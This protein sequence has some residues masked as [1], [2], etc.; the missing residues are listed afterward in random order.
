LN[1]RLGQLQDKVGSKT[2]QIQKLQKELDDALNQVDVAESRAMEA[3]RKEES[4]KKEAAEAKQSNDQDETSMRVENE[5][6]SLRERL[7]A[8]EAKVRQAQSDAKQKVDEVKSLEEFNAELQATAQ[9][10]ERKVAVL[11]ARLSTTQE[12]YK[13]EASKA[14]KGTEREMELARDRAG[15]VSMN[16]SLQE[17]LDRITELYEAAVS[18]SA[19]MEC[20]SE[21]QMATSVDFGDSLFGELQDISP[22]MP[23]PSATDAVRTAVTEAATT[24]ATAAPAQAPVLLSSSDAVVSAVAEVVETAA[25]P[26]ATTPIPAKEESAPPSVAGN[27][28]S[29]EIA[30][31]LRAATMSPQLNMSRLQEGKSDIRAHNHS[32]IDAAREFFYMTVQTIIIARTQPSKRAIE[33]A[34]GQKLAQLEESFKTA[35]ALA[36]A[37]G[38]YGDPHLYGLF[39]QATDGP[40]NTDKPSKWRWSACRKW[41]A[42]DALGEMSQLEAMRKYV[43]LVAQLSPSWGKDPFE[44]AGRLNAAGDDIDDDQSSYYYLS[45]EAIDALY[46]TANGRIPMQDWHTW[47][48][49]QLDSAVAKYK[50]LN[51]DEKERCKAKVAE[52]DPTSVQVDGPSLGPSSPEEDKAKAAEIGYTRLRR[53]DSGAVI[54]AFIQGQ[55]PVSGTPQEGAIT[56]DEMF[57]T[58]EDVSKGEKALHRDEQT[59]F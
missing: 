46:K 56:A 28:T 5:L 54:A 8:T 37:S 17:E 40:C 44:V 9:R 57:A 47:V 24:A 38:N 43:E 48:G 20:F 33:E 53:A 22:R 41:S 58:D 59:N 26:T 25:T 27:F 34:E 19:I 45:H 12:A 4:A 2:E 51:E 52:L 16:N 35:A 23:R 36:E 13:E 30:Q 11:E 39:K 18:D 49:E 14:S 21:P 6:E 7:T 15:L 29:D 55:D 42:W 50:N 3:V 10:A 31:S 1:K 32:R